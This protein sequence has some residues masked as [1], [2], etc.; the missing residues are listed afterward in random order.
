MY[1]L[2][3]NTLIYFFKGLGNVAE[4]L[5]AVAPKDIGLPSIVVFELEVGI[6]KS[7]SPEKR[8]KQLNHLLD[9]VTVL[10]FGRYEAGHAAEIRTKLETVGKPIGPYDILI[11]ATA[12]SSGGILVTHNTKE[13]KRIDGLRIE[14]WY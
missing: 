9:V 6:G 10:P 4:K 14:D 13:F 11:A 12:L 7:T 2:D 3:T 5:L 1:V 8:V